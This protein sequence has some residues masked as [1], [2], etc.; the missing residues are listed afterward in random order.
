MAK[1]VQNDKNFKVLQLSYAEISRLT[2]NFLP[3]CDRCNNP[4]V[5]QGYYVAVLNQWFCK[6]CYN[7]WYKDAVN[8]PEDREI[9][10]RN[11]E[12]YENLCKKGGILKDEVGVW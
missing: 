2:G 12:Y 1:I 11:Y 3:V 7:S 8:Y 9:E 6:K 5:S 10:N 4:K